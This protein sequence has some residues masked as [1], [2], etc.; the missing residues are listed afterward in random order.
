LTILF[1]EYNLKNFLKYELILF[2]QGTSIKAPFFVLSQAA[3][4]FRTRSGTPWNRKR[5][6]GNVDFSVC[7]FNRRGMSVEKRGAYFFIKIRI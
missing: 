7:L 1:E 4:N 2:R 3:P 6:N 5:N